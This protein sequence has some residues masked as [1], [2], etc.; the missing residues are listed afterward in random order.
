MFT[1][2]LCA[3]DCNPPTA[4]IC[5]K[6]KPASK[7]PQNLKYQI[8]EYS[9]KSLELFNSTNLSNITASDQLFGKKRYKFEQMFYF[10][11]TKLRHHNNSNLSWAGE[12]LQFIKKLWF[13][14]V[15]WTENDYAALSLASDW[16]YALSG[17]YTVRRQFASGQVCFGAQ[18]GYRPYYYGHCQSS[19]L[20]L[21]EL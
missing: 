15:I 6:S 9:L 18:V 14:T 5:P 19:F 2:E 17:V 12:Q 10:N 3:A 4:A 13:E 20:F 7:V 21:S 11:S 1:I 8:K 16:H